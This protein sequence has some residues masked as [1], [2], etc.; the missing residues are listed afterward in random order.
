MSEGLLPMLPLDVTEVTLRARGEP[1]QSL[2]IS[3]TRARKVT[4]VTNSSLT[5]AR[6]RGAGELWT[7]PLQ[8]NRRKTASNGF[9]LRPT[10]K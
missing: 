5:S 1:Q 6:Q 2:W 8:G 3:D 10:Q 4:T 7:S 9:L